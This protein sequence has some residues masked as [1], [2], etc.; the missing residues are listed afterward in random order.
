MNDKAQI[1]TVDVII[2]IILVILA[3][4]VVSAV[5]EFNFY[6]SKQQLLYDSLKQKAETAA[7][8]LANSDWSTCSIGNTNLAYSV[9]FYKIN[10]VGHEMDIKKKLGL[11][12]YNVQ[13]KI[14]GWEILSDSMTS[15]NV[16]SVDLNVFY[17][18]QLPPADSILNCLN[19]ARCSDNKQKLSITVGK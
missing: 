18:N 10:S 15:Q 7:I 6:N 16:V 5:A 4:G 9:N 17:C 13:I 11:Q 14:G 12:D 2:S 19:N 8:V 3:M 1:F